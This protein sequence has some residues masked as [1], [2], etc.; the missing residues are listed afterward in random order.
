M[1]K[2]EKKKEKKI[3]KK[4]NSDYLRVVVLQKI[5]ILLFAPVQISIFLTIIAY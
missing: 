3:Q 5:F 4:V 1:T 2:K